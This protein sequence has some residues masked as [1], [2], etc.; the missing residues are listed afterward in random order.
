MFTIS[1]NYGAFTILIVAYLNYFQTPAA[2]QEVI[3]C[4]VTTVHIHG[5]WIIATLLFP[6]FTL[7][8]T[9]KIKTIELW[10]IHS[11]CMYCMESKLKG[12]RSLVHKGLQSSLNDFQIEYDIFI[13][14][15]EMQNVMAIFKVDSGCSINWMCLQPHPHISLKMLIL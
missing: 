7:A 13:M 14:H 9:S 3:Q 4:S 10:C 11:P 2:A 5:H 1:L 6:N 8:C 15:W 12:A